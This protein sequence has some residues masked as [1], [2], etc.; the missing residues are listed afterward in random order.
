MAAIVARY[1]GA[2][3]S[4]TGISASYDASNETLVLT[5]VDSIASYEQVLDSVTFIAGG[6]DPTSSGTVPARTVSWT[7]NDGGLSSTAKTTTVSLLDVLTSGQT[8]F[9]SG[10]QTSTGTKTVTGD[11]ITV[12]AH[13]LYFDVHTIKTSPGPLTVTL[14]N[15]GAIYHTFKIEGTSLYL[16]TN[17]GH[18]A[19]GTVTLTK[20]T[21]TF[22]CTVPGHAAAGMKGVVDVS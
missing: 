9:V 10:G 20:G 17:A 7:V 1:P 2:S 19:T 21:Y 12:G 6:A 8:I 13:D 4:G 5:N 15:H 14:V 3:A 18:A 16:K 11:S 22:E